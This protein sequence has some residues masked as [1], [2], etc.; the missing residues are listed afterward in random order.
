MKTI[1]FS[2]RYKKMPEGVEYLDTWIKD[3]AVVDYAEL[4]E[5]EIEQDTAIVSGGN[6]PLPKTRLIWLKLWSE[7]IDGGFEW[8]TLRRFTPQK[9]DYYSGLSGQQVKI[10][11]VKKKPKFI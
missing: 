6:Y 4:T 8:G 5:E 10:E 7:T 2:H 9:F 11:I 3:V 1:K